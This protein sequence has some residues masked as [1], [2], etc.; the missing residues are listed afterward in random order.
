MNLKFNIKKLNKHAEFRRR[1]EECEKVLA[2]QH[3]PN[4][5][6]FFLL[7]SLR[8][9]YWC[10]QLAL[11]FTAWDVDGDRMIWILNK[12][13][14][15]EIYLECYAESPIAPPRLYLLG[16]DVPEISLYLMLPQADQRED[17]AAIELSTHYAFLRFFE[18]NPW[19]QQQQVQPFTI[20]HFDLKEDYALNPKQKEFLSTVILL[21]LMR[22]MMWLGKH[23]EWTHSFLSATHQTMDRV[24]SKLLSH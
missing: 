10:R 7:R 20:L 21:S 16:C 14:R 22:G 18:D 3:K 6:F 5:L 4:L 8:S 15:H 13:A 11:Q 17:I 1:Q 24:T 12:I 19:H 23:Q 9:A 2:I